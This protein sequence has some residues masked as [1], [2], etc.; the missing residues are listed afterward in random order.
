MHNMTGYNY[1][2]Y[3]QDALLNASF[4][5]EDVNKIKIWKSILK[6]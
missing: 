4:T 2:L 6:V 1:G 3:L 5:T